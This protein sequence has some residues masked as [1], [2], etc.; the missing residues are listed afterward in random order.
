MLYHSMESPYRGLEP[1]R[2]QTRRLPFS[3]AAKYSVALTR[4][5]HEKL[6]SPPRFALE[7]GS[8]V[9]AGAVSTWGP[10]L[11]AAAGHLLCIDTW[12]ARIK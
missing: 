2:N 5:V 4:F 6:S 11:R 12:Q 1:S 8:F 9:G 10:L 3:F 7:V